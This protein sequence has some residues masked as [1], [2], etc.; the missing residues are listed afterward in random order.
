MS[1]TFYR[2]ILALCFL[3]AG[4]AY[5]SAVCPTTIENDPPATADGCG[6]L[7]TVGPGLNVAISLTGTGAYDG[8]SSSTFGV[9]NNSGVPLTSLALT[10]IGADLTLFAGNGIRGYIQANNVSIPAGV[11][12]VNGYEDYY[13]PQTTFSNIDFTTGSLDVDFNGS[14]LTNSATYFSLPGD[15]QAD[16]LGLTGQGG[17]V[18]AIS[19]S[20]TETVPEIP[21]P[22][23]ISTGLLALAALKKA[24]RIVAP[25]REV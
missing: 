23:M 6:I 4:S 22:F 24:R 18:T 5:G 10:T 19:I 11:P 7:L 16:Y 21:I 25:A 20:A 15:P 17:G 1:V 12:I 14:L 8:A 3:L 9:I 2:T 13:G